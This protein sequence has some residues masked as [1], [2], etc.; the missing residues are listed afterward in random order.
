LQEALEKQDLLNLK[1]LQKTQLLRKLQKN[2]YFF[3]LS[4]L[5]MG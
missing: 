1:Q 2:N 4:Q 3:F 5:K